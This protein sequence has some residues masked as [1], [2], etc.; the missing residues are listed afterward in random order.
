M[1][2]FWQDSLIHAVM[3]TGF[4][5]MMMVVIEYINISSRGIWQKGLRGGRWK[6][7]FLAAILGGTPGCLGAFAVVSL[8]S[9]R[10]VT[11]GAV[12]V[13][14][15]ATSGD[16]AFVMLSLMPKQSVFVFIILLFLGLAAGYITDKI[17]KNKLENCIGCNQ[18]FE[19]H[20]V[21]ACHCSIRNLKE[22]WQHCIPARGILSV[23]LFLFL[24]AV[25]TSQLGPPVWNWIKVTLVLVSSSALFIVATVPDHFLEEHLWNHVVKAHV[26]R[27]FLWTFG[28]LLVMHLLVDQLDLGSWLQ[29]NQLIVLLVACLIGLIPESGPHLIFLTLYV[30]GSV[31]LSVFLASSVV[32]DG[33]GMLPLLAESPR[34]FFKVKAVNLVVGV[35]V[36]IFGFLTGW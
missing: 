35:L 12:V 17:F 2:S 29:E 15:I 25:I 21:E 5:A 27:I 3:I 36:G 8:Y 24:F 9:H 4:V 20:E 14:M 22:Q 6:Q 18:E 16:E 23:T 26:P 33:H 7:Y 1:S 34:D 32:Q 13:A 10:E 30:E 28:A 11:F 19:I 31:P